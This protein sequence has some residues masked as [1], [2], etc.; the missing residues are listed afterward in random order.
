MSYLPYSL[1]AKK[2]TKRE[3]LLRRIMDGVSKTS[4]AKLPELEQAL[5]RY[6]G[7]WHV[8]QEFLNNYY[9]DDPYHAASLM[10]FRHQDLEY[11]KHQR[12]VRSI[13]GQQLTREAIFYA[14]RDDPEREL[15]PAGLQ[16]TV[17]FMETF[18]TAD[19]KSR[20]TKEYRKQHQ[21]K[22]EDLA[23]GPYVQAAKDLEAMLQEEG[24]RRRL[25]NILCGRRRRDSTRAKQVEEYLGRLRMDLAKATVQYDDI[26]WGISL[27]E[28]IR[29]ERHL[30]ASDP[31]GQLL[32]WYRRMLEDNPKQFPPAVLNA[33]ATVTS[34][35][36]ELAGEER[37]ALLG[38]LKLHA[39][40]VMGVSAS[41]ALGSY[42]E[43]IEYLRDLPE[44]APLVQKH[45]RD[46]LSR[47]QAI[48]Q[49]KG[50]I[51]L[52]EAAQV[53]ALPVINAVRAD[54]NSA[55]W[56]QYKDECTPALEKLKP[57]FMKD[58]KWQADALHGVP[59]HR[60]KESLHYLALNRDD[61]DAV[62]ELSL[63]RTIAP[64][65]QEGIKGYSLR[66]FRALMHSATV[67]ARKLHCLRL[68]IE[69][70]EVSGAVP[71]FL[72]CPEL[73]ARLRGKAPGIIGRL[74][75][76]GYMPVEHFVAEHGTG[77]TLADFI[78]RADFLHR[79]R[80]QV[81]TALKKQL[82]EEAA[83]GLY[84][85]GDIA[86]LLSSS[87][88]NKLSL[89]EEAKQLVPAS[90]LER[91]I[92]SVKKVMNNPLVLS[93]FASPPIAREF[94]TRA[95]ASIVVRYAENVASAETYL[96]KVEKRWGS[97][98]QE[99][100]SWQL[101]VRHA[102]I[103]DGSV[104]KGKAAE[105]RQQYF[106]NIFP[107]K[108]MLQRG[109]LYI[110]DVEALDKGEKKFCENYT[111]AASLPLDWK[112]QAQ[113]LVSREAASLLEKSNLKPASTD[114]WQA[115]KRFTGEREGYVSNLLVGTVSQAYGDLE[116]ASIEAYSRASEI[117][118]GKE[119][120]EKGELYDQYAVRVTGGRKRDQRLR[121]MLWREFYQPPRRSIW[122]SRKPLAKG[123]IIPLAERLQAYAQ[124][125]GINVEINV[126]RS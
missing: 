115:V 39:V 97:R 63:W 75:R 106:E 95:E 121:E 77:I 91:Y 82:Q 85:T 98:L 48:L 125:E 109:P 99:L 33:Y 50:D 86:S 69:S 73:V 11:E 25:Q 101:K 5:Q 116:V 79:Q 119:E 96:E 112:A 87:D 15:Y 60:L 43:D 42:R 34:P 35:Y 18:G 12:K 110:V 102:L 62:R 54:V 3:T 26:M 56:E 84:H 93:E 76:T 66:E 24:K 81:W 90:G 4:P 47:L 126:A 107:K 21:K 37:K 100:L 108:P 92:E 31:G 29:P 7:D 52:L 14:N 28:K 120:L 9:T 123:H 103:L 64:D 74:H 10:L 61:A 68:A 53:Y 80:K 36:V 122:I 65:V 22:N 40:G 1:M 30:V 23:A 32:G 72:H 117:V 94:Y 70:G 118:E 83:V 58:G 71:D 49:E 41:A 124:N 38:I 111:A 13:S 17:R 44:D 88:K 59:L 57:L 6:R 46:N 55:L 45:G 114:A 19:Q 8:L 27:R 2:R 89:L 104:E 20:F 113:F 51:T 16:A 105:I 78:L 67:A